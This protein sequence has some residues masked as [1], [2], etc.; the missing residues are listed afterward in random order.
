MKTCLISVSEGGAWQWSGNLL[1]TKIPFVSNS[2][3]GIKQ[4]SYLNLNAIPIQL[5]AHNPRN[6]YYHL[7]VK[8]LFA[9][10]GHHP[11]LLLI[12][13]EVIN[14]LGSTSYDPFQDFRFISQSFPKL[15]PSTCFK[16]FLAFNLTSNI[17][18]KSKNDH[19]HTRFSPTL[20]LLSL[21]FNYQNYLLQ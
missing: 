13:P 5:Y 7:I 14:I 21:L 15:Y 9:I 20:S 11:D 19:F 12:C 1:I 10:K 4:S 8:H 3:S 2:Y 18:I 6:L 16:G 17:F